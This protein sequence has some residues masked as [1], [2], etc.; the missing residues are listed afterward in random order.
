MLKNCPSCALLMVIEVTLAVRL[1]NT[2]MLVVDASKVGVAL[3]ETAVADV[4]ARLVALI[5]PVTASPADVSAIRFTELI[6][7]FM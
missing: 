3:N 4:Y 2:I 1:P 6:R 5:S 7:K